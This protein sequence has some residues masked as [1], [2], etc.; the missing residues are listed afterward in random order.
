MPE[1][2]NLFAGKASD[3]V[4]V[5]L[6]N[7]PRAWTL[8]ELAAEAGVALSWVSKVSRALIR[9]RLAIRSSS[10]SEL[11]LMVPSDLLRR[12]ANNRN[13]AA[14]SKFVEY[15]ARE[16]DVVKFLDLF[17]NKKGPEYALTGLAGALKVAPY[18]RP[19]NIHIYV[20]TEEDAKKWAELLDLMPIEGGGNVKFAIAQDKRVF[21]GSQEIGGVRV[22]SDIQLYVDLLNYPGRGEEAAQIILK[23]IEKRWKKYTG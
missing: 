15:Y 20:K 21:Y 13:F 3:I 8:R 17:K 19:T 23:F 6:V 14:N 4:R 10:R 12:W 5:L 1:P 7:Y 2:L 18:V 11:R 16:E 22:V 9:E